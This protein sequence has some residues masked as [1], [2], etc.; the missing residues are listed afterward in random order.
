M[1]V[2]QN[3]DMGIWMEVKTCESANPRTHCFGKTTKYGNYKGK[4]KGRKEKGNE[5]RYRRGKINGKYKLG[6]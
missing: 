6:K 5:S 2:S 4:I 1:A 3:H